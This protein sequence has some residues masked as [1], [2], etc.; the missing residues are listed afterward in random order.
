ML[1][2]AVL[3][4]NFIEIRNNKVLQ[5]KEQEFETLVLECYSDYI[6]LM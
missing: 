3:V 5:L 1:G 6:V 2:H 4:D